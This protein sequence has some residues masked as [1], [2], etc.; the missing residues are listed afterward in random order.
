[1]KDYAA[2]FNGNSTI[3]GS[4]DADQE[5]IST[6]PNSDGKVWMDYIWK[7]EIKLRTPIMKSTATKSLK[8]PK[9]TTRLFL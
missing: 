6:T 2:L 7:S 8:I 1:M 4:R 3:G 9:D 5:A